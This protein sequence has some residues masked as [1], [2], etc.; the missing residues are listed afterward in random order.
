MIKWSGYSIECFIGQ[1]EQLLIECPW[2]C[3]L[4]VLASDGLGLLFALDLVVWDW[5]EFEI[6]DHPPFSCIIVSRYLFIH[7]V[8]SVIFS[9]VLSFCGVNNYLSGPGTELNAW[10]VHVQFPC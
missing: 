1:G 5:S 6:H 9:S 2:Y 3:V 7:H 4:L 8:F 10:M